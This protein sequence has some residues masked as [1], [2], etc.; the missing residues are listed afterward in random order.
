[1]KIS[2][3]LNKSY[4]SIIFILIFGYYSYAEE[5]PVDIWNIDKKKLEN[6]AQKENNKISSEQIKIEKNFDSNIYKMQSKKK[7]SSISLEDEFD[8][9]D[10]KIIGLY[11]PEDYGLDINMWSSSNGDQLK[12]LL[13]KLNKMI[14]SKDAIEIVNISLLTNSHYPNQNI[15]E[16]EFL[17]FKSEW[18]IKNSDLELIEEYLIKNQIIDF[19]PNLTKFLVDQYLAS[20]NIK[21]VCE[22]FSNNSEPISDEYLSKLNIYCL[23][24][25]DKRE[26]A[27]LILDLKKESGFEDKYFERRINYLLKYSDKINNKISEKSIFDFYL[28]HQTNPNFYFEPNNQTKKIIWKYLSSANLLDSFQEVD[29]SDIDKIATIEKAVHDKNYPEKDLFE[30]YKKFQFN[31][32]QLLNVMDAY[33]SLSNIEGRALVYQKVL[34]ES[35]IV[36]K[37]K[38]LKILKKSFENDNLSKAF[39][40]ELKNFLNDINPTDIPDNLTSFYYTNIKIENN[41]DKKIKFN[42]DII[43]QSKLINYFNGDYAK[44]KIAKDTNNFLKKIKKNKKYFLSKKDVILL[45]SLKYDGI[46]ISEKYDDLYKIDENEIPSDIQIMI[47]NNETGLALLRIAEVIGQ[48]K[49]ERIDEDTIYFIITTLNKLNI[50]RIRNKILLQVLPLKV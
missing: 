40:V 41:L 18:L 5:Q 31:I 2:K 44:T 42:N 45:E 7:A 8:T 12:V 22:I 23:I 25:N 4:L 37:L 36:E 29:I 33:K 39:D 6:D 26:E 14:L 47:N 30:L 19:H 46:E 32:N 24:R 9:Q 16:E 10:I 20:T 17:K 49:I 28:A 50:D 48:D 13:K 43:H 38:L 1:M 34:L 15:T 27:Q 11:D 3:L 35:E 21:K